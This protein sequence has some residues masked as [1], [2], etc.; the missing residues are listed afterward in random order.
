MLRRTLSEIAN[1]RLVNVAGVT[2]I[3][4]VSLAASA[5][6]LAFTKS[7]AAAAHE[8]AMRLLLLIVGGV[9]GALFGAGPADKG[10]D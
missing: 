8:D 5:T 1:T 6:F 3:I 9:L 4:V 2:I 10:K 7:N